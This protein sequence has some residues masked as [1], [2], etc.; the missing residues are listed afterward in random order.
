LLFHLSFSLS[1]DHCT[2]R[3]DSGRE[4]PR[5]GPSHGLILSWGMERDMS[6]FYHR[7]DTD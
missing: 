3:A 1:E 6:S 2:R 7:S 5:Q 4:I